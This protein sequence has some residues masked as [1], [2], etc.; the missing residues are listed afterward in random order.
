MC[1]YLSDTQMSQQSMSNL[2]HLVSTVT[3]QILCYGGILTNNNNKE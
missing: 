1:P 3:A 2:G